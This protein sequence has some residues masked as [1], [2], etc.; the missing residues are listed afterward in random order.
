LGLA[1][2]RGVHLVV[3]DWGASPRRRGACMQKVAETAGG[4]YVPP[5]P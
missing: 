3:D 1:Q 2:A 4:A 5:S